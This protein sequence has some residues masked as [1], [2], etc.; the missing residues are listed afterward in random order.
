MRWIA[1]LMRTS[2][3]G[4]SRNTDSV[5][6]FDGMTGA[7]EGVLISS[8]LGGL[9]GPFGMT[10]GPNGNLFVTSSTDEGFDYDGDGAMMV[11]KF[12]GDADH[13]PPSKAPATPALEPSRS[14]YAAKRR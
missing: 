3:S 8:G 11:G 13:A 6:I 1:L 2:I 7:S 12:V 10:V 4:S 5:L 14:H 9:A